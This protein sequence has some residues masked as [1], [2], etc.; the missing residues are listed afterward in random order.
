M[1]VPLRWI[2]H[3]PAEDI[4]Y[5]RIL[6]ALA[7]LWLFL[8]SFRR[9]SLKKDAETFR[10]QRKNESLRTIGLTAIAS[11]LI[12]GNWFTYIYAVNH[13]SVQSAAFGYLI[14]PLITAMAAFLILK[15]RLGML[16]KISLGLALAAV[17][18]LAGGS[19]T[20]A[21]WST[22]IA[23]MYAFYLVVQ[24]ISQ[25]FD[26][27]HVL[28]VQLTLC[29]LFVVPRLLFIQHP[30]P[31]ELLFWGSTLTIAVVFTIIPL[32]LSMYALTRISSTTT[33][34]LLYINPLIAFTLAVFHFREPV[35]AYKY[36]AY[37]LILFAIV[38]FN[39]PPKP[40]RKST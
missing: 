39:I 6:L 4:L 16:K 37:A 38:L 22:A 35:E 40:Q 17:L 14:C 5:Y 18:M 11:V 30:I 25:G 15:E 20:E 9:K 13:I 10:K 36:A 1:A 28:A 29:S 8:L 24:R 33:G 23:S 32:F 26:K 31:Q 7:V 21:M 2:R 19:A 34:V 12:F 3:Y 27:L